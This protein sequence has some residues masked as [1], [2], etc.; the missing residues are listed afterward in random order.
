MAGEAMEDSVIRGATDA[1]KAGGPA[2]A[3]LRRCGRHHGSEPEL[4]TLH[5]L[6]SHRLFQILIGQNKGRVFSL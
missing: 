6:I 4:L 2:V 3:D 1:L 5:E